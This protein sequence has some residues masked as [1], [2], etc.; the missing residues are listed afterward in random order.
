MTDITEQ[1]IDLLRAL[2]AAYGAD[3]DNWPTQNRARMIH[4]S[5]R[6]EIAVALLDQTRE[7]DLLLGQSRAPEPSSALLARVLEAPDNSRTAKGGFMGLLWPFAINW[8][9]VA[10]MACAL[11]FGVILGLANPD[12]GLPYDD[13]TEFES[14]VFAADLELELD[15]DNS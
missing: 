7:L 1:E 4:I 11:C 12:F 2:L 13:D 14:V 15:D 8:K 5:E 3:S 6:S 9:P 10:G